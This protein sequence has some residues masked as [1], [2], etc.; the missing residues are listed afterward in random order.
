MHRAIH[1]AFLSAVSLLAVCEADP[2]LSAADGKTFA[3]EVRETAGI[4]RR[5][6]V[7]T[8]RTDNPAIV[9]HQ[10]GFRISRND[11]PISAQFRR[12]ELPG[13]PH[14]LVVDFI[15]HFQPFEARR[16]S[17][18]LLD[19]PTPEEPTG[20]LT[21][22]ETADAYRIDSGSVL[23]W[24][25]RKDLAGLLD[26][27]WKETDYIAGDSNGLYFQQQQQNGDLKELAERPPTRAAVE[28]AG[29]IAVGLRFDYDDWPPGAHSTVHLEFPRT[30]SWIHATWTIDGDVASIGQLGAA[31]NLLLDGPEA[32][33]DFKGGD[34]VYATVTKD[35]AARLQAG[36]RIQITV[37]WTV[38]HG[39][40]A[41]ME[42][43]FISPQSPPS[44][45]AHGWAHVM[46]DK[47]CTA[48]AIGKFGESTADAIDVDGSGR[49]AWTR[50]FAETAAAGST[51]TLEFWLHFVTMPVH[52]GA[53]T[54][55]RSMQEPLEVRWISE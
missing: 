32:L 28:R 8:V 41:A 44:T 18:E 51:R 33:I 48:L 40:A 11:E 29:P 43:I 39:P 10:G 24:T 19:G 21:L 6:D 37:P 49:L 27:A 16:Y 14:E 30:K 9:D 38:L 2:R 15:D 13:R 5:Y 54:S 7:V 47:R 45:R 20:G 34:F 53:R 26:F 23:S 3:F 52:I 46:D 35:Q 4:R 1:F 12:V 50:T 22:T 31:L 42:P 36:P 25:I 17:L 55:P